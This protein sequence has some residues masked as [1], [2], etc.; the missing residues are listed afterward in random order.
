MKSE[1]L[2]TK[3]NTQ[4]ESLRFTLRSV[5]LIQMNES[6][7]VFG[8]LVAVLFWYTKKRNHENRFSWFLFF[9]LLYKA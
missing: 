2:Y 8:Y 7:I 1:V 9:K 3:R 4:V 5:E 6:N